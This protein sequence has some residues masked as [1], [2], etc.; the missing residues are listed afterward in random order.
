L[1]EYLDAAFAAGLQLQRL[2]DLPMYE[3]MFKR[4]ATTWLPE[5]HHFPFF[6]LLSFVKP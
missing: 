5:G 2:I 3:G 1:Q 6:M 4:R